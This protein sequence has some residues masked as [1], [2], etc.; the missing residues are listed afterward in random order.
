MIDERHGHG[1]IAEKPNLT[2]ELAYRETKCDEGE[3]HDNA[4]NEAAIT[5]ANFPCQGD[6]V[7]REKQ[8]RQ[9]GGTAEGSPPGKVDEARWEAEAPLGDP[10]DRGQSLDELGNRHA[11]AGQ[12]HGRDKKPIQDAELVFPR[13]QRP[14]RQREADVQSSQPDEECELHCLRPATMALPDGHVRRTQNVSK[15]LPRQGGCDD[16]LVAVVRLPPPPINPFK[17][18]GEEAVCPASRIG[19]LNCP[20]WRLE[21][22]ACYGWARAYLEGVNINSRLYIGLPPYQDPQTL[23]ACI[24]CPIIE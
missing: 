12:T 11:A 18:K 4:G 13:R 20:R 6:Q 15:I 23:E 9:N 1:A 8:H 2:M 19:V 5:V 3:R 16:A 24:D 10:R 22:T 21:K 7:P 17:T 14:E